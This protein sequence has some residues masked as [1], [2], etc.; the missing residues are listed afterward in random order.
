MKK[1]LPFLGL[2]LGLWLGWALSPTNQPAGPAEPQ[3]PAETVPTLVEL[4]DKRQAAAQEEAAASDD[5]GPE[6]EAAESPDRPPA[7]DRPEAP[8]PA[9]E[10][11][12]RVVPGQSPQ[13]ILRQL[14]PSSWSAT[15]RTITVRRVDTSSPAAA[16]KLRARASQSAT[17]P[18]QPTTPPG[19]DYC[20]LAYQYQDWSGDIAYAVCM[21]ESSGR[22]NAI[23]LDDFHDSCRG[24][25]GL[26]Q[27]AC[28]HADPEAMLDPQANVAMALRIY[29]R[30]NSW[31]PWG[32]YTNGAYRRYLPQ[33]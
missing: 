16:P 24:S 28:L 26:F 7:E 9:P 21:A 22:P 17:N 23:N 32:A 33:T 13:E 29:Q 8:S 4:L 5:P 2:V 11:G 6:T 19:G 12:V 18:G 1:V 20:L 30:G 27:I 14:R 15:P 10:P 3:T 25:Y 31:Q